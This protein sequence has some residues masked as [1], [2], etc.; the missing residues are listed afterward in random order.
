MKTMTVMICL[1]RIPLI[2]MGLSPAPVTAQ[3][4]VYYVDQAHPQASDANPGTEASPWQTIQ[5]AADVAD[6]G[7]TV[8]VKT[9]VY[10]ERVLITE[11]GS[12]GA[13]IT[14]E[15]LPRR[16]VQVLHG[17]NVSA[18]GIRIEGFEITHDEGGWLDGGI[19]MGGNNVEL[20]DNYIH[21]VPGAGITVSWA[22]E[23][24]WNDVYIADNYIYGCNQGIMSVSGDS[25]LVENNEVERLIRPEGGSDADYIRFF[26]TN[27]V[28]RGNYFHGTRQEEIGTSHTDCFQTYDNNDGQAHNVLFENNMCTD[29]V[30]QV[31]MMEGTGS[32]HTNITI[33]Y[34]VFEGF[35]AWGVC[36]HNIRDLH[37]KNNTWVGTGTGDPGTSHGVGFRFGSTGTI[38]NNIFTQI[39]APYWSD[40]DSAYES[41]HNLTFECRDDPGPSSPTDLLDTDPMFQQPADIPGSDGVPWTS[42]DGLHLQAG[43]PAIDGGE[44]GTFIGAYEFLPDLFLRGTP[45]D[46][47]IHLS[48]DVNADLPTAATWHIDYYTQTSPVYTATEPLSTTRSTVL[49]DHVENYQWYTVTLHAMDGPSSTL[50]DTVQVMPTGRLIYLPLV[51]KGN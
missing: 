23:G 13:K 2:S 37:V 35:A 48:W 3:A 43:S 7:D 15:A 47:A 49:T 31:F 42:D 32:S 27:H 33:R 29:F 28:I 12:P 41:G 5:H 14:F 11:D 18:D 36:A 9:G 24:E 46:E 45:T 16:S 40:D 8:Y 6:A 44:G 34:N 51:L 19:W 30:H 20:V 17:F 4:T 25:W 21:S 38:K 39:R 22:G 1:L 10:D 26:G 50:S